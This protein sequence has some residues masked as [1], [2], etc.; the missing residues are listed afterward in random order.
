MQE[1]Y[2]KIKKYLNNDS[3][4]KV[5]EKSLTSL[6]FKARLKAELKAELRMELK[7][8]SET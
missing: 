7:K 8:E 6:K 3:N 4:L 1:N 5:E 2:I